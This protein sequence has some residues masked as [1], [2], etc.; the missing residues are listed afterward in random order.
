MMSQNSMSINY[1]RN[2]CHRQGFIGSDHKHWTLQL[3]S[4][5]PTRFIFRLDPTSLRKKRQFS[6]RE[7]NDGRP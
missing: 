2:V 3:F 6:E 7:T 4:F 5:Q 1:V